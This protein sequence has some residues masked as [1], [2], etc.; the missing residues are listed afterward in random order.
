MSLRVID[1]ILIVLAFTAS[2]KAFRTPIHR[3]FSQR[4]TPLSL[5]RGL[6][7]SFMTQTMRVA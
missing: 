7:F 1:R 5:T 2:A 6:S 3:Q 4:A